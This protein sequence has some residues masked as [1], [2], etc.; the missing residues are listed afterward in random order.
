MPAK[1]ERIKVE[2]KESSSSDLRTFDISLSAPITDFQLT[3]LLKRRGVIDGLDSEFR[4]VLREAVVR[5]LTSADAL[6]SG[7]VPN[8][9]SKRQSQAKVTANGNSREP[10]PEAL[11]F[12]PRGVKS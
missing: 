8:T 9:K 6:I 7:L 11:E 2:I 1:A 5:Y 3:D 12:S 4:L 10:R